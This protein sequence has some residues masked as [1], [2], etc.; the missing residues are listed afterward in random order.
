MATKTISITEEAYD[1]LKSLKASEKDSFSEVIIKYYPKKRKLSEILAEMEPNPELADAIEKAS[2][3]MRGE[4]MRVVD[5]D[6]SSR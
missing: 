4:K 3:E 1:K 5:F 6:A 2:K